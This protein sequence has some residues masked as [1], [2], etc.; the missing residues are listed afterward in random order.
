MGTITSTINI[1]GVVRGRRIGIAH[2]FTEEDILYAGIASPDSPKSQNGVYS[3]GDL[4]GGA[5]MPTFD[6]PSP[7]YVMLSNKSVSRPANCAI[8]SDTPSISQDV[9]L[10]PNQF[11]IFMSN[12]DSEAF[13]VDSS[14]GETTLYAI[15]SIDVGSLANGAA[16]VVEVFAAS[17]QA[18]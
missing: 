8:T 9:A 1:T 6:V 5:L 17:K 16:P 7:S 11:T 14:S 18:S 12:G 15:D 3:G 13:N 2:S 4:F 10:F